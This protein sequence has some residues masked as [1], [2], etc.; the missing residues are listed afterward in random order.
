MGFL[1]TTSMVLYFLHLTTAQAPRSAQPPFFP[2]YCTLPLTGRALPLQLNNTAPRTVTCISPGAACKRN[3]DCNVPGAHPSVEE[4]GQ[5]YLERNY[6]TLLR[7]N[8]ICLDGFCRYAIPRIDAEPRSQHRCGCLV[9]CQG[10]P[11]KPYTC[12]QGNCERE[13]CV[14]C[15]QRAP[16][17][18]EDRQCCG[19]AIKDSDGICRCKTGVENCEARPPDDGGL[20]PCGRPSFYDICC[21]EG[22]EREGECCDRES[23]IGS[24]CL[25]Q[26]AFV[27][28]A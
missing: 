11:G 25:H 1:A 2:E 23:C 6:T 19:Y 21:W 13:H 14:G 28:G 18:D 24:V 16:Y 15:G 9:G 26:P 5:I 4:C 27:S 20:N 10:T 22:S 7:P 8:T 17:G 12:I 3:A